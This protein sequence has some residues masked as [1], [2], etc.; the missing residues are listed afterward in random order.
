MTDN[1]QALKSQLETYLAARLNAPV[2][3]VDMKPL[4]GG[5]CQ[6]NWAIDLQIG[7]EVTPLV[8][9]TDKGQALEGSLSREIEYHVIEAAHQAGVQTPKPFL[10][11]R[12]PALTGYPF[13]LMQRIPGVAI[14]RKVLGDEALAQARSQL[15]EALAGVLAHVHS[16]KPGDVPALPVPAGSAAQAAIARTLDSLDGFDEPHPAMELALRW[17]I[18]NAPTKREITLVHGDFRTGNFM[19]T[20]EGLSGVLDWEFAHYGD[21]LAD[22]AWL[23]MRDWRFGRDDQ[24][25][26]GFADREPFYRAY[27]TASGRSVEPHIVHYW[28]VFGNMRWAIGAVQQ[29]ARH[30]SGA[31]R[32]IELAA[33]GRRAAE[34]EFEMLYLIERGPLPR[35]KQEA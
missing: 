10:L 14:A 11:E 24:H 34:M 22:I 29:A 4:I 20:P 27:E 31:D 7:D 9:R 30:L 23:C 19:V 21:P 15:P 8:L 33:I 25:V 16:I 6:D 26:G 17:L 1:L 32:S 12:S 3:V 2:E 18:A 13:Y 35:T 28:E 5:A